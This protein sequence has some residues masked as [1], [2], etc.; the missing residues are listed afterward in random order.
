[1]SD[2]QK[3]KIVTYFSV[4]YFLTKKNPATNGIFLS[5]KSIYLIFLNCIK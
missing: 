4:T 3:N 5:Q 1:M 2:D